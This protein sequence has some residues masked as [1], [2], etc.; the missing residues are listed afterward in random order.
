MPPSAVFEC[1]D[2]DPLVEVGHRAWGAQRPEQPEDAGT[3]ADLG[4]AGRA[5]LDVGG[6]PRRVGRFQLVK[7]ERVDQV[8]GMRAVQGMVAVWVRHIPYM[9]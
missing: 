6:Q 9:T 5:T 4:G 3:A 8:A 2:E 1:R 7:Q